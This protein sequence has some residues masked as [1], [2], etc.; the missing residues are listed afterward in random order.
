MLLLP[1]LADGKD[2]LCLGARPG[3]R[4]PAVKPIDFFMTSPA[5][6]TKIGALSVDAEIR[7]NMA[8]PRGLARYIAPF[9]LPCKT[10]PQAA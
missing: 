8:S 6:A 4:T 10:S 9:E 5:C 7:V 3:I 1:D 2:R